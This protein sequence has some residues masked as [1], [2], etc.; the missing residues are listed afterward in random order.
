MTPNLASIGMC[1]ILRLCWSNRVKPVS[2]LLP[3]YCYF[4]SESACFA[5][6]PPIDKWHYTL[7]ACWCTVTHIWRDTHTLSHKHARQGKK[8]PRLLR[9]VQA[10][11]GWYVGRTSTCPCL[12]GVFFCPAP[13]R[14]KW[15]LTLCICVCVCFG[16]ALP[17]CCE[18][19]WWLKALLHNSHCIWLQ[20]FRRLMKPE[21]QKKN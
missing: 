7:W 9:I 6:S 2:V 19:N 18:A 3:P 14:S 5:W 20:S 1:C 17:S 8:S 10:T 15:C 4:Y 13:A 16:C 11:A 12:P 21:R